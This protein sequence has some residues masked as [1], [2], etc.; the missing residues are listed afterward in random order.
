MSSFNVL[1]YTLKSVTVREHSIKSWTDIKL[2]TC[3]NFCWLI[4]PLEMLGNLTDW[5]IQILLE[6][7]GWG[8]I[9]IIYICTNVLTFVIITFYL[10]C[11]PAFFRCWDS[12]LQWILNWILY[13]IYRSRFM[14][15]QEKWQGIDFIYLF[16]SDLCIRW[17]KKENS[18]FFLWDGIRYV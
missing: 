3:I 8:I 4:S 9:C 10:L 18:V 6:F 12:Q 2:L 11:P 16:Y 5:S 1:I 14:V 7:L 13:W 15:E 17:E